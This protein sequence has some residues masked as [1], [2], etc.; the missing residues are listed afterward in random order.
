MTPGFF[1]SLQGKLIVAS[2][3]MV[4]VVLALAGFVFVWLNRGDERERKLDH[5]IAN[6]TAIQTEFLL[7]QLRGEDAEELT[8]FIGSAADG[9][10]VRALMIDQTGRVVIDSQGDLNGQ[11]LTLEADPAA[12]HP[13]PGA[14]PSYTAFQPAAG[15][16][17]SDL[18]L[19]A[20]GATPF[21][22][23]NITFF[24]VQY[25]LRYSLLLAV[26]EET[27]TRPTGP[28]R[29][30]ASPRGLR[31][32]RNPARGY[33]RAT[34][35]G[36]D[37]SHGLAGDG[38]GHLRRQRLRRPEDEVGRL[39]RAFAEM[40]ERVG[41]AHTKMR[42]LV[43]NISHDMKTP[44]TSIIGFSQALR[45]EEAPSGSETQRMA[46]IIHE[47]AQ[48]LNARLNDLLYLSEIES[49]QVVL[50]HDAVDLPA[51]LRAAI[52]R[53]QRDAEVR[54]ITITFQAQDAEVTTDA[55]KLERIVENLLDNA[56]KFTPD[57]GTIAVRSGTDGATTGAWVEINS[58]EDVTSE[59]LPQMF[60]R[61][62]G[63]TQPQRPAGQLRRA[64][65][66]P[67]PGSPPGRRSPR[68]SPTARHLQLALP[69]GRNQRGRAGR[70]PARLRRPSWRRAGAQ[71]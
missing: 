8:Q 63:G 12:G 58:T 55:Q 41:E 62:T 64:P 45:D 28:Y 59:E 40:A 30:S 14:G 13:A 5:V 69:E 37:D 19:I 9:Y 15:S 60:D 1:Q 48:R 70:P 2:I 18:V 31:A 54:G 71:T 23:G 67:R 26:S 68:P 21:P 51:L 35:A 53:I 33:R 32:G 44:L 52:E 16:P 66:R 10:E 6:S 24:G 61:F 43:G 27:L 3:A 49:G 25:Q 65:H 42:T 38:V 57:G 22:G 56:R 11:Q 20:S 29:R 17:G 39:A 34:A 7:H 47:E 4:L 50:Q 46:A 36:L